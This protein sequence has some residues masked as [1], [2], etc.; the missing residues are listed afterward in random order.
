MD[1]RRLRSFVAVAEELSFRRAAQRLHL[2][3]PPLSRQIQALE[4]EVGVRLLERERNRRISLTDA[5]IAFL[6][7]TKRML[8]HADTALRNARRSVSGASGQLLVANIPRLS[9]VVLP[10][11]LAAFHAEFPAVE[12]CL[13]EMEPAEQVAAVREKRIH[14]GIYPHLGRRSTV[15]TAP[16]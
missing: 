1:L 14:L 13:V 10:P 4:A 5:G 12:V 11:M 6:A 2:S 9:T 7:D 15:V 8:A 3:Q 16:C